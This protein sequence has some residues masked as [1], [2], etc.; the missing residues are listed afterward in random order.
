ME[1]MEFL[2]VKEKSLEVDLPL[3]VQNQILQLMAEIIV[4]IARTKEGAKNDIQ[5][6]ENNL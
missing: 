1:Q 4:K 5:S 3:E 2:L 6:S